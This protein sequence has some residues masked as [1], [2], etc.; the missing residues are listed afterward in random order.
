MIDPYQIVQSRAL[1]ADC[2]LLILA[3]LD[4][5]QLKDLTKCAQQYQLDILYEVHDEI[6][7]D[8]LLTT[9]PDCQLI[10]INNRDLKDFSVNLKT[11]EKLAS[12][13][14]M[15]Q[16][17]DKLLISESGITNRADIERLKE[18]GFYSFLIGETLMRQN[19]VAQALKNL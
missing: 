1:G 6:E 8:R 12:Y 14:K 9:V 5:V 18:S 3:C 4:D 7:I 2:I 10:G 19:D 13:L 11:S 16:I 17:T 15:H